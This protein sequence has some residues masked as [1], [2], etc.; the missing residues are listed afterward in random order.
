MPEASSG[1]VVFS[2]R[3]SSRK[4]GNQ[5]RI[6]SRGSRGRRAGVPQLF[7]YYFVVL[8]YI[9]LELLP[10]ITQP[11]RGGAHNEGGGR[12]IS[13]GIA[14]PPVFQCWWLKSVLSPQPPTD[15]VARSNNHHHLG[16]PFSPSFPPTRQRQPTACG[17]ADRNKR[18]LGTVEQIP[19]SPLLRLAGLN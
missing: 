8:P 7:C 14:V 4:E 15:P 16:P 19:R 17:T 13:W 18:I 12:L 11:C 6:E 1:P 10:P 2:R 3:P 5:I 9:A